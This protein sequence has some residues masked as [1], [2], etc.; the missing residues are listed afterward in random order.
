MRV[1][2]VNPGSTSTKLAWYQEGALQGSHCAALDPQW[3]HLPV[4]EQLAFRE[5]QLQ[6]FVAGTGGEAFEA[7][8]ALGGLLRPGPGGTYAVG[9]QMLDD[10]QSGRH[11]QHASGLG[12]AL[13]QRFVDKTSGRALVADPI[14]TDELDPVARVSGVPG[15]ERWGRSHALSLK[16]AARRAAAQLGRELEQTRQVVL[17]MGGGISVAALRAG[18]IIDVNDAMLG[19]GPFSPERAGALPLRGVLD[20]AFAPGASRAALESKL[21]KDSGLTGYLGTG[22]LR[23][24][25]ARISDGDLRAQQ[26]FEAMAYQIVKEAGAMAAAL[27][28]DVHAVVMTGGMA[29][30]EPLISRLTRALSRLAPIF[31]Y[32]GELEMQ[33]LADCAARALCGTDPI[34]EYGAS[35]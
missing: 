17:H 19:M 4:W 25:M 15:I 26:V 7:V 10:L 2:V 11:G 18:R 24:V 9:P 34:I 30:C 21:T 6:D 32:P 27:E 22:D 1:L 20:L 5:R 23:V 33:A 16:A 8:I 3:A 29:A 14:S 12:A 28:F 31:A 13:A 35:S